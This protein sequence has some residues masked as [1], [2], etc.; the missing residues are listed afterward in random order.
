MQ[1]LQ[2]FQIIGDA[3]PVPFTLHGLQAPQQKLPKPH[4]LLDDAKDR[5][6]GG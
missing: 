5:L 6:D 4:H 3:H 1:Y 2:S